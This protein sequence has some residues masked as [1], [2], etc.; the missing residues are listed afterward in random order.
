MVD[1]HS[2][3]EINLEINRGQKSNQLIH[4]SGKIFKY[5]DDLIFI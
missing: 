2:N 5:F 4:Q 1:R 3:Y